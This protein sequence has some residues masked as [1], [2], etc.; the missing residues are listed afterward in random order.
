MEDQFLITQTLS[1][2]QQAFQLIVLRYQR[3]VFSFLR[4]FN[5]SSERVEELAQDTFIR[6]Y[7]SLSSFDETKGSFSSWLLTVAKNLALNEL[8]KSS[9]A[10]L[11]SWD[12]DKEESFGTVDMTHDLAEQS[13]KGAILSKLIESLPF[14][15]RTAERLSY[16]EGLILQEIAQVEQCELGTVKSRIYRGKKMLKEMLI[17]GGFYESK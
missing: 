5:L 13:E 10:E 15:F 17:E 14:N 3:K 9:R 6:S 7:E 12:Q 1:G 11:T 4:K 16:V 2:N 8:K